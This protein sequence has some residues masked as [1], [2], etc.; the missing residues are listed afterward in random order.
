MR[1]QNNSEQN[2]GS[3]YSLVPF[4]E[5]SADL[6]CIAGFDGYF[7]RVNASVS[8]LLGY[9]EEELLSKP[10]TFFQ[11]P[12]DRERT[13][14]YRDPIL[15]GK[16]L[17]NFENRYITKQGKVIWLS[18]TSIPVNS[19]K[20]IYAIAKN[21]THNKKNEEERNQL[22]ADVSKANQRLK[23]LNYT[24]S[25]DLRSPVSNL[26]AVF[27]LIDI[28]KIEDKETRELISLLEMSTEN[29]K[30]TLNKYV[31]DL[32][33]DV[34][35]VQVEVLDAEEVLEEVKESIDSYI[36]DSKTT[37]NTHF[38]G[39]KTLKFNRSYLESI[40]LNLITNSIKYAHP[41]RS[42]EITIETRTEN[43]AKI[44]TFSDNG[45]GFDSDLLQDKIFGLYQ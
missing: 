8:N 15:E 26:M 42:P 23:Q 37:F 4:F 39:F 34:N 41:D 30:K 35:Q 10:I 11:H 1:I 25:H 3:K 16:E 45:L 17:V 27:S 44:L 2:T 33:S 19:E 7:R 21:V 38:D 28:N 22:L 29:L 14:Q 40:F 12:D 20:L 43:E 18:W 5:Q 9:T 31:D 13:K 6:M 36:K 24:T 32:S